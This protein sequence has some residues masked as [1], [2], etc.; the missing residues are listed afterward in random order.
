MSQ[1]YSQVAARIRVPA[2]FFLAAL[3]LILAAPTPALLGWGAAVALAG[4]LLR[5]ASAGY[6]E[7]NRRLATRGPYAYTRN[8]L[9]L[10]SALA[11]AGLCIA[12][13]HGWFFLL[14][15]VFLVAVYW[16]V[17][18]S[19]EAH[20]GR[21]FPEE[22]PA[23]ARAV[24]LLWPRLRPWRKEGAAPARFEWRRYRANR[25]YE[26]LLAYVAIV[27]ILWGKMVWMRGN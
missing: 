9:Y 7:K 22:F 13:G 20:L 6:L 19:E 11:G 14:L 23:Y 21:L 17:L 24:P 12:A 2:G 27:L 1:R 10:G 18:R 4:L 15:G 26:A 16:P 8:P 25:E 3:F 5:A